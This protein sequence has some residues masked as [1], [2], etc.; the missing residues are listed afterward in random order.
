MHATIEL[1]L[2][3]RC[4]YV[5]VPR[6]YKQG[7]KSVSSVREAREAA[8][9]PLLEAVAKERLM[10][11]QQAGKRLSV[12]CGDFWIV[13]ISGDAVIACSSKLCVYVVN[14]SSYQSKTR[15]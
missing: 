4:F 1:Q 5:V 11:T 7:T 12:C 2:E 8:E 6:C 3:T 13:E 14:K 9:S 15:L 10:K